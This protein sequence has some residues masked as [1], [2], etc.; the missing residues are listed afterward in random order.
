[1]LKQIKSAFSRFRRDD[2]GS[3]T[4]EA[5]LILPILGWWYVGS[6]VFFDAYA[7]KGVNLKA[8]YTISDLLSRN[9]TGVV[10]QGDIKGLS[11]LFSYLTAGHGYDPQIRVT[12]VRCAKN[13]PLN[14]RTLTQEWSVGTN[15]LKNLTDADMNGYRDVIPFIPVTD[16]VIMVETFMSY[17]P[18]FDVGLSDAS[19]QNAIITRPRFVSW[20]CLDGTTCPG[21]S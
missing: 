5:V 4:V 18:A 6:L 20:P 16:P 15:G 3:L 14:N 10:T 17:T 7:A 12:I 21:D 13:C 1:M 8:S 11:D 9:T 19:Y 2:Q